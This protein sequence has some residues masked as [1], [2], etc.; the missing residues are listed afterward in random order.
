VGLWVQDIEILPAALHNAKKPHEAAC[1]LCGFYTTCLISFLNLL[2]KTNVTESFPTVTYGF[3]PRTSLIKYV[4][5][6]VMYP[7]FTSL[8][9][10]SITD[11]APLV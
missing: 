7:V 3:E 8:G 1:G 5:F 10:I 6:S 9:L 11:D 2:T 4:V